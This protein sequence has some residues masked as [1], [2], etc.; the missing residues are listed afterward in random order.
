VLQPVVIV[1]V[2]VDELTEPLAG[3]DLIGSDLPEN[4]L[5]QVNPAARTRR[6]V[7]WEVDQL[8]RYVHPCHP[9]ELAVR[10]LSDTTRLTALQCD[11]EMIFTPVL[12]IRANRPADAYRPAM[13]RA[14][15]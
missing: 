13:A 5:M 10:P 11:Y 2:N 14:M 6:L 3:V 12:D 4:V 15:G 7:R 8:V 1:I 9:R